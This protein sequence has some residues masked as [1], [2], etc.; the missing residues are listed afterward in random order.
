MDIVAAGAYGWYLYMYK[1]PSMETEADTNM[2]S[3]LNLQP[4]ATWEFHSLS[5]AVSTWEWASQLFVWAFCYIL[6]MCSTYAYISITLTLTH[7]ATR[8]FVS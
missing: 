7:Q 4:I 1:K 8:V 3:H 2:K 5:I 6:L